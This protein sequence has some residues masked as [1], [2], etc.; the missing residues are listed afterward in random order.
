MWI[1]LSCCLLAPY[2]VLIAFG[3]H[4]SRSCGEGLVDLFGIHGV[5]GVEASSRRS[6]ETNPEAAMSGLMRLRSQRS[7][8][9]T[10]HSGKPI[11]FEAWRSMRS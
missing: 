4:K 11:G 5:S 9:E 1:I 6:M 10:K 7:D 8:E 2:L 3:V